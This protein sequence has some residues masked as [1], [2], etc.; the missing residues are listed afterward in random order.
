MALGFLSIVFLIFSCV[1]S[2]TGG[3]V[4]EEGSTTLNPSDITGTSLCTA[5][6]SLP[7]TTNGG[8]SSV[9]CLRPEAT[10]SSSS[11]SLGFDT[12]C[13]IGRSVKIQCVGGT[14]FRCL[15]RTDGC[16]SILVPQLS[17]EFEGC[18]FVGG[19]LKVAESTSNISL[20]RCT[21]DGLNAQPLVD[22]WT[23]HV[24]TIVDSVFMNGYVNAV[25]FGGGCLSLR[26]VRGGI[27]MH[28]VT[29][30]NCVAAR[31]G[32]CVA[33]SGDNSTA[34]SPLDPIP[35]D[36]YGGDVVIRG[37]VAEYCST[38]GSRGG[39]LALYYMTNVQMEN[40]TLRHGWSKTSEGCLLMV[41]LG[42]GYTKL[43]MVTIHNCTAS[44]GQNAC[45]TISPRM[46]SMLEI[47]DLTVSNCSS[48]MWH[49]GIEISGASQ[50]Y[51]QHLD[52]RHVDNGA[53]LFLSDSLNFMVKDVY[54]EDCFSTSDGGLMSHN[55]T[56][57]GY[58]TIVI[59]NTFGNAAFRA[60]NVR[61][62]T[63]RNI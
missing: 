60:S 43:S 2:S 41:H 14:S 56:N 44:Y 10:S 15:S 58:E 22:V 42:P 21:M 34:I 7:P 9:L 12:P 26:G 31:N 30:R 54:I 17:V 47:T 29:T 4:C 24:V 27:W 8:S 36:Q 51:F 20:T 46:S 61:N 5:I 57:A 11:L 37:M 3:T 32:G 59:S 16:F 53:C 1:P 39:S 63:F 40:V 35:F 50:G 49:A 38:L 52:V 62:S 23:A 28:N 18:L 48:V 45:A 19:G 33:I 25:L 55:I 13:F 6:E